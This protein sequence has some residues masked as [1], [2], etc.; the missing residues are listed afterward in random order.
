MEN[1]DKNE[2]S[3]ELASRQTGMS[4]QR[5]RMSADKTCAKSSIFYYR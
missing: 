1:N 4:F 5:T 3:F 2:R